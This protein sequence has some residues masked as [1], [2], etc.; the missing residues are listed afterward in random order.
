MDGAFIKIWQDKWLPTSTTYMVQTPKRI[1]AENARVKKLIDE[2]TR[3]WNVSL[4]H[5]VF[6]AEEAISIC[7]I[8]LSHHNSMIN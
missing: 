2:N 4:I 8:P 1:L 5:E 6:N 3:W 7:Q